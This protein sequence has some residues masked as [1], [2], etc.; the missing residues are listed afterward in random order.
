MRSPQTN[1][2][3]SIPDCVFPWSTR[4]PALEG[5]R[6]IKP[7]TPSP[8]AYNNRGECEAIIAP[9]KATEL[10]ALNGISDQSLFA[11]NVRGP[12]GKTGVNQ[13]IVKS[14]REQ[15]SISSSRYFTTVSP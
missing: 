7:G 15:E 3:A 12:L 1:K 8:T 14:I 2:Y 11:F 9:I 5:V 6:S 13:D 4:V 10:V